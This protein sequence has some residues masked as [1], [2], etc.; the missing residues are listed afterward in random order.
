MIVPRSC[1]GIF[2]IDIKSKRLLELDQK[3]QNPDVWNDHQEMQKINQEKVLLEKSV[4]DY[5]ELTQKLEDSLVL[6]E[7]AVE[8]D[9]DA[10]F[11][12]V[13]N[14]FAYIKSRLDDLELKSLL[15][16]E[17]DV[18]SAFVAIHAGAGGTESQDWAAMLLRMY[19]RYAEDQGYRVDLL[20]RNDG[21]EAGIKSANLLIE[22]PYAYGYLKAESGV[23]RLVR[24]SPFDANAR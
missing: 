6:L 10:S 9:D 16:G 3:V 7:M 14:D 24:I 20:S 19:T 11:N 21:E 22:G 12:E 1:G 23:H 4:N 8:A 2:D 5:N 17:V 15:N 13:K 18:N